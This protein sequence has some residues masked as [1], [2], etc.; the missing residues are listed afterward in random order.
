MVRAHAGFQALTLYNS[1]PAADGTGDKAT[2]PRAQPLPR[3][4][5]QRAP[6][7]P[8]QQQQQ[9]GGG[10]RIARGV[11]YGPQPRATLDIYIPEA[12]LAAAAAGQPPQHRVVLFCHGGVWAA[13]ETWHYA[14]MGCE[15]ARA[16]VMAC[17][18]QYTLYPDALVPQLVGEVGAALD[19]VLAHAHN[20]GGDASQVWWG[21][22]VLSMNTCNNRR[23]AACPR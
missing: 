18:M 22:R 12:G 7:P 2:V 21:F 9:P 1:L 19:W 17:V 16:G 4:P 6:P 15:L 5:R 13:G 11:R 8:Q 23:A 10:V 20:Y 3:Q 14:P